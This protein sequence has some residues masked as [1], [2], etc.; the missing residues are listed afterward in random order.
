MKN[1]FL[2]N[3][4]HTSVKPLIGRPVWPGLWV[5]NDNLICLMVKKLYPSNIYVAQISLLNSIPHHQDF[6]F[7]L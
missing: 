3:L 2:I 5:E 1:L 4:K 6:K 7:E